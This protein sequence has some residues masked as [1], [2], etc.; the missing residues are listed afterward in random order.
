MIQTHTS[1]KLGF[2]AVD[3]LFIFF[4]EIKSKH[5]FKVLY[6]QSI[7]ICAM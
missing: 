4:V 3:V 1:H 2:L 5:Y 7:R 6:L